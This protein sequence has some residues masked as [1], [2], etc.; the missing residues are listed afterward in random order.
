[1]YRDIHTV[2]HTRRHTDT[3]HSDRYTP[4]R[5]KNRDIHTLTHTH[6]QICTHTHSPIHKKSNTYTTHTHMKNGKIK[7]GNICTLD[8]LHAQ[9]RQETIK[10]FAGPCQD[11]QVDK[12][13]KPE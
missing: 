13:E 2:I 5:H 4:L 9:M 8:K 6:T 1:M 10:G 11:L 3:H 12:G 7:K